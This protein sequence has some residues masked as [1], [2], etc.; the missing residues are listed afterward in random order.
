[1]IKSA[2]INTREIDDVNLACRQLKAQL[3][4]KLTLMGSS[5][6][7][8]QC[9]PEFIT[10]GIMEKLYGEL[11]IPLAGGT[12]VAS[13]SNGDAGSLQLSV[14]VLTSDDVE[15]AVSH[16][17]GLKEN[18]YDAISRSLEETL[19]KPRK[20]SGE[21]LKLALVF[22]PLIEAIAAD[23]Y[24]EAIESV[25]GK[26]PIFGSLPVDD[27]VKFYDENNAA[28]C[29]SSFF[30][31]EMSYVLIFGNIT[32]RFFV[33]TVS[34]QDAFIRK[35][36]VITRAHDNIV[37]EINNK[38]AIDYFESIGLA[39]AGKIKE[40]VAF[41]PLLITP[42]GTADKTPFVRAFTRMNPDGSAVFRGKV[43][44]GAEFTFGCTM[45]EDVLFSTYNTVAA[46][47]KEKE[48]G[49]A[50]FFSCIV[51]QLVIGTDS[52]RELSMVK[53]LFESG[54]PFIA[55]YAGGEISPTSVDCQNNAQN[56][57]HNY[58]FVAC[59]L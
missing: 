28:V 4:E 7:I 54:I 23:S 9:S 48:I 13:A 2:S 41:I 12:T 40:G 49:A 19:T 44:E 6:G 18:F 34:A 32:P 10:A 52:M 45:G 27:S 36:P 3:D 57:F 55:S 26:T 8:V 53:D 17:E 43:I 21:P 15:F 39:A 5:V 47:K 42:P 35:N 31:H 37:Y 22:P 14:L 16:T 59:L 29:N 33:A 11:N 1:M 46:A 25:C 30:M 58:S 24:I 50:L 56:R 51:R 38:R 20:L